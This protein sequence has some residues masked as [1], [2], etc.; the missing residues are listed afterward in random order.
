MMATM[1]NHI[2]TLGVLIEGGADI[3]IGDEV[4]LKCIEMYICCMVLMMSKLLMHMRTC[5]ILYVSIYPC[6][7]QSRQTLYV[8]MVP[9]A[10]SACTLEILLNSPALAF[11]AFLSTQLSYLNTQLSYSSVSLPNDILQVAKMHRQTSQQKTTKPPISSCFCFFLFSL[12]RSMSKVA[13][14]TTVIFAPIT[15]IRSCVHAFAN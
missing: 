7:S 1:G 6:V 9:A 15:F 14:V 8:R 12:K 4:N 10:H 2:H 13:E 3:N 11:E 5:V